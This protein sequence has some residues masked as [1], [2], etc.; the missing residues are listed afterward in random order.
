VGG[1]QVCRGTGQVALRST[2]AA[3]HGT[4]GQE[5]RV[6]AIWTLT[7]EPTVQPLHLW[8]LTSHQPQSPG[9]L[10]VLSHQPRA[11]SVGKGKLRPIL[12]ENL[13]LRL[14]SM[15]ED[16]RAVQNAV[17]AKR[18]QLPLHRSLTSWEN[19]V[20]LNALRVSEARVQSPTRLVSTAQSHAAQP[21]RLTS[22]RNTLPLRGTTSALALSTPT[23]WVLSG[24]TK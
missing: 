15:P 22:H 21:Q 5:K 24:R 18:I 17:P 12:N 7:E 4:G 19:P 10:D 11:Y 14:K 9:W 6:A 23:F 2:Q 1:S 16:H 3:A 13:F 8:E 20:S